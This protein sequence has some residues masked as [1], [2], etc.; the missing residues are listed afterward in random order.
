MANRRGDTLGQ[1]GRY[2]RT[3]SPQTAKKSAALLSQVKLPASTRMV[4]DHL[5]LQLD[6]NLELKSCGIPVHKVRSETC[7]RWRSSRGSRSTCSSCRVSPPR[8]RWATSPPPPPRGTSSR[9]TTCQS[10]PRVSLDFAGVLLFAK[11]FLAWQLS[12][13]SDR[14]PAAFQHMS[15]PCTFIPPPPPLHTCDF[16]GGG[17][18]LFV[19]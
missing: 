5:E 7:C 11:R 2:R 8:R 9:S 19:P 15:C 6:H 14:S 4:F 13:N 17:G 10:A 1:E 18:A 12:G 16:G 3:A